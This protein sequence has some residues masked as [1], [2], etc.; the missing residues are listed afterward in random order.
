MLDMLPPPIFDEFIDD[1]TNN[2]SDGSGCEQKRVRGLLDVTL[3]REI[4]DDWTDTASLESKDEEDETVKGE[5]C[6]GIEP[7]WRFS[8]NCEGRGV[9]F[10]VLI[11][12]LIIFFILWALTGL[13]I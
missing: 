1:K 2:A 11:V 7:L 12:H 13:L 8:Y 9:S 10:V 5:V 4:R 3:F 6:V